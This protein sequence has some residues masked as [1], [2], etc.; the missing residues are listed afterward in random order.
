MEGRRKK[1]G[2][3]CMRDDWRFYMIK[4]MNHI[5]LGYKQPYNIHVHVHR[6]GLD[7]KVEVPVH[8]THFCQY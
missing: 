5:F 1:E 4:S 7:V 6:M 3:M 8:R 2:R